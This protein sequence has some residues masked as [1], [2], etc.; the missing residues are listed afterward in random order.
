MKCY[1]SRATVCKYLSEGYISQLEETL[2]S[3]QFLNE[4]KDPSNQGR[5]IPL[6]YACYEGTVEAVNS[7]LRKDH[8]V[9]PE[10]PMCLLQD[11]MGR[12][13]IHFAANAADPNIVKALADHIDQVA[14]K[15][16]GGAISKTSEYRGTITL[17]LQP[18]REQ[19]T[20]LHALCMPGYKPGAKRRGQEF[21]A[22]LKFIFTILNDRVA[23]LLAQED[24][25]GVTPAMYASHFGYEEVLDVA[26]EFISTAVEPEDEEEKIKSLTVT[27]PAALQVDYFGYTPLQL[28]VL[29]GDF[30]E[31]R[32]LLRGV[33]D[34]SAAN[35]QDGS[36][37]A[38]H[39][40]LRRRT[41]SH[42]IVQELLAHIRT[43]TTMCHKGGTL[44]HYAAFHASFASI[45]ALCELKT[46]ESDPDASDTDLAIYNEKVQ[47]IIKQVNTQDRDGRTALHAAVMAGDQTETIGGE[48]GLRLKVID[49]LVQI[50]HIDVTVVDIHGKNAL[51]LAVD[52]GNTRVVDFLSASMPSKAAEPEGYC[53]SFMQWLY[54][55]KV[56]T[57]PPASREPYSLGGA[58]EI[59]SIPMRHRD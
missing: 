32:G 25:F 38:L 23:E 9:K 12:T 56:N 5:T 26:Q 8:E 2:K 27:H 7:L 55:S 44:L 36:R 39:M 48:P 50:L 41:G 6:M 18:D 13:A 42:E 19:R 22:T 17:L 35:A 20:A 4:I 51:Q 24:K 14:A 10:A 16:S 43:P 33:A 1:Y 40:A 45:K 59:P 34:P 53:G 49:Y 11:I 52:R 37:N 47:D 3:P 58:P 57:A 46:K 31:I 21:I 15:A 30:V 28:L 29:Y 54:P